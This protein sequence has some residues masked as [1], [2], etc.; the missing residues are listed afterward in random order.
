MCLLWPLVIGFHFSARQEMNHVNHFCLQRLKYVACNHFTE[1]RDVSNDKVCLSVEQSQEGLWESSAESS[2]ARDKF[3]LTQL[4]EW[5]CWP[6]VIGSIRRSER[7][8]KRISK[9]RWLLKGS[10]LKHFLF[11]KCPLFLTP[12]HFLFPYFC[13]T[14]F[15]ENHCVWKQVHKTFSVSRGRNVGW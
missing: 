14:G 5:A 3:A 13:F 11:V 9:K 7:G 12:C 4:K 1:L 8:L 2:A 10:F 6:L 15:G